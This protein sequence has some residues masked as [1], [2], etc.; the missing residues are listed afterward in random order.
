MEHIKGKDIIYKHRWGIQQVEGTWQAANAFEDHPVINVTW[1]G[2]IAYCDWLSEKEGQ[3]YRLPSEAEWEYVAR[4]GVKSKGFLYAGGHKLKEVG[5]YSKNSHGQ[6]K[7]VGLKQP[8]ELGLYDMSGNVREWC[9]DHWH[10]NYNG[11]PTDGS[12]WVTGGDASRRVVRGGS[13]FNYDYRCRVSIASGTMPMTGSSIS[14][15]E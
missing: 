14:V 9:A 2:A 10:E 12:A 4:G 11:A 15:F 1:Y 7:P 8:N 6:T 5:W 13:W 3:P